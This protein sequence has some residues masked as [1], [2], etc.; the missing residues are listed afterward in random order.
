MAA[1]DRQ[2]GNL[3]TQ[4]RDGRQVLLR[5]DGLIKNFPGLRAL[6]DVSFELRSGE[7]LA[8]VGQNGSGKSTLVK[9]LAGVYKADGGDFEVM[10]DDQGEV[11]MHFIHQTRALISTMSTVENLALG[12]TPESAVRVSKRRERERARAL[13]AEFGLHF[14]VDLPISE[15]SP[16]ERTVVA[17]ARALDGWSRP[18]GV[19]VL[20]EPTAELHGEEA[21]KLFDVVRRLAAGGAGVIFISHRLDEVMSIADQVLALRDGCVVGNVPIADCDHDQLIQMIVGRQIEAVERRPTTL[22]SVVLEARGLGGGSVE[23]ADLTLREGE[24]LGVGGLIGSGRESLLGLLFGARPRVLGEVKISGHTLPGGQIAASIANRMA[25]VPPD[26]ATGAVMDMS[27]RENLTLSG[28]R[29]L[30]RAFGRLDRRAEVAEVDRWTQLVGLRPAMPGRRFDL[31]SGGN[32]QKVMIAKWLR[33]EPRALL[34]EE[35]TQGVDVGAKV[36]IYELLQQAAAGG[37]GVMV[38]SADAQEL[39]MI[40]DRVLVMRDGRI[41]AEL[42]G[43]NLS[44]AQLL[45]EELALSRSPNHDEEEPVD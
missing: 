1:G 6:D 40:C 12:R 13:L 14:D 29:S 39:S 9:V 25:Y 26:R 31:F 8:I 32:Q 7:V 36:A 37:A 42:S 33:L 21:D 43:R 16:A 35:P 44:E 24:I 15:I 11:Q 22:G 17:I 20:D 3:E 30:R 18:E 27:A 2:A 41:V 34:L 5:A 45:H 28:L 38:A 10:N 23:R 19:I 4:D